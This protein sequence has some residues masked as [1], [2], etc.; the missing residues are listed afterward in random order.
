ME[1]QRRNELQQRRQELLN[2]Q[3]GPEG[4]ETLRQDAEDRVTM[5]VRAQNTPGFP[6]PLPEEV[7][8]AERDLEAATEE[9]DRIN[10]E[11]RDIDQELGIL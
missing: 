9:C 5:C 8:A 3:T 2:K 1:D 6:K 7:A 4:T 10:E 11:L